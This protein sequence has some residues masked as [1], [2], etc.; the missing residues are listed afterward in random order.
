MRFHPKAKSDK[1]QKI[2]VKK[3]DKK[4]KRVRRK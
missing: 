2:I 4:A 1:R 3:S